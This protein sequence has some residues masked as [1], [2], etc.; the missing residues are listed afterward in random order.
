LNLAQA[1]WRLENSPTDWS[2]KT[3]AQRF[4]L[5]KDYMEFVGSD[6]WTAFTSRYS[7]YTFQFQDMTASG[8]MQKVQIFKTGETDPIPY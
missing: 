4:A 1:Q 2:G 6:D 8:K 3:D 7:P 5:I